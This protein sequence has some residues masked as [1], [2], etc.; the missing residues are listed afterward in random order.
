MR[1]L[2]LTL[3]GF[4]SHEARTVIELEGRNLIA[5]VGPTGSG[6]SSILDALCYA[7]YGK[8]SRFAG[9]PRGLRSLICSRSDAAAVRL[10][11]SVDETTWVVTRSLPRRGAG[12]HLLEDEGSGEKHLGASEVTSR[13]EEL[14]GLD[15][16][17]FCSSVLLAQGQFSRFLEAATTERM[18]ILK[19]VFRYDQID[20]L[21]AAA[22]RRRAEIQRELDK[23]EGERRQIPDDAQAQLTEARKEEKEWSEFSARLQKAVPE[24]KRLSQEL[25]RSESVEREARSHRA[26]MEEE[27]RRIP[28]PEEFEELFDREATIEKTLADAREE[29]ARAS[30]D[31]K[32]AQSELRTLEKRL[33]AEA[34]LR[35]VRGDAKNLWDV[36]GEID[37]LDKEIVERTE[38]AERLDAL[39]ESKDSE[40]ATRLGE[41]EDARAELGT[42]EQ[43]HAA[44]ALRADL[45]K[46]EPCPVCEQ[47]VRKVPRGRA[48]A[49]LKTV[50]DALAKAERTYKKASEAS[51][52]AR[53][54][55]DQAQTLLE[56]AQK[57]VADKTKR[58]K[59]LDQTLRATL[60]R[61]QNPLEEIDERLVQLDKAKTR[62]DDA[63]A[64]V[65]RVRSDLDSA[66]AEQKDF[67]AKRQK[68]AGSLI[69][70][71]GK[72]DLE[73]PEVDAPAEKLGGHAEGVREALHK[74]IS[75]AEATAEKAEQSRAEAAGALEDL[76]ESLE[77]E[78]SQTITDALGDAKTQVG[79]S[80]KKI[81]ELEKKIDR[82]KELDE[83]EKEFTGRKELFDQLAEDLRNETFI[84]FLLEDRRRLLSDLGSER[85]REMTGRYRFDDEGEFDII[86]ELDADKKRS[87]ETLSG[88]ETFLASLALAI[89]L[90][91]TVGRHGGRL[92]C[93]FI[94]EGFGSLDPES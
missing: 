45:K 8:T 35:D 20:E 68:L 24:E 59:V 27:L 22:V 53:A 40:E 31:L 82:A 67:A 83:T 11:F 15:F 14:L 37:E 28:A 89:A 36:A 29:T 16:G 87:V 48:P 75:E 6:K 19:G 91:E 73:A 92:Q 10:R 50:R 78:P 12:Q 86:D 70:T 94:D 41:V 4:R 60:G 88:G 43:A 58:F 90:A 85:L 55:A 54:E 61:V 49:A 79:M 63:A 13:I 25:E 76:R 44:H 2:T 1:P 9:G 42:I 34:E 26:R 51:K 3:E 64:L 74:A 21:R 77:L 69:A 46:G 38:S 30:G 80:R 57:S 81:A 52:K 71:S 56:V 62:V 18:K 33:G 7:L 84:N 66:A 93:F 23:I 17:A 32:N 39:A 65:E 5:I 72:L 47:E